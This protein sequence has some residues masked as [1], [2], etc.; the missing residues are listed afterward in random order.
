[1]PCCGQTPRAPLGC[2]KQKQSCC[3]KSTCCQKDV[4]GEAEHQISI[5]VVGTATKQT[6]VQ[7]DCIKYTSVLPGADVLTA[8]W[9][10]ATL[11]GEWLPNLRDS[12]GNPM[13]LRD[14]ESYCVKNNTCFVAR[15]AIE[16]DGVQVLPPVSLEP[17]AFIVFTPD[18]SSAIVPEVTFGSK[19]CCEKKGT[20]SCCNKKRS[21]YDCLRPNPLNYQGGR[22]PGLITCCFPNNKR[23]I[24]FFQPA[25][26]P[27]N[28]C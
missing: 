10:T 23:E 2:N 6:V 14:G 16:I 9:V 3:S 8:A 1:M 13:P 17:Q 12:N 21:P 4:C 27:S 5:L 15:F 11:T 24:L 22:S 28:C 19:S 26:C 7:L 18:F 25:I 20:S